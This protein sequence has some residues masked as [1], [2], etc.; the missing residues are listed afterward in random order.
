VSNVTKFAPHSRQ[1]SQHVLDEWLIPRLVLLHP[2][3]FKPH[4]YADVA[5]HRRLTGLRQFF[6]RRPHYPRDG[7]VLPLRPELGLGREPFDAR[8]ARPQTSK[9]FSY[10]IVAVAWR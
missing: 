4:D 7:L 6:Y 5:H 3:S 2:N 9:W 8:R 1:G 10:G